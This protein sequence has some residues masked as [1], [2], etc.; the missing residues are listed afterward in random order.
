MKRYNGLYEKII[1]MDNLILADKMARK[2]KLHSYGVMLFDKNRE[3]NLK[4]LHEVL[5]NGEYHTSKYSTFTIF[6]PKERIIYR[7]PYFPDRIMHHAIMNIMCDIWVNT[8]TNDTYACIKGRGIH[9]CAN[10]IKHDLYENKDKK[11]YCLKLDIR[12]FYPSIDHEELKKVIRIK[13]KDNRLL[14]LL[15]EIIDSTDGVPIGNYLSQFFAN[16]FLSDIDHKIKEILHVRYYYRYADD[17]VI[18][19]EKKKELHK[20]K[21]FIDMQLQIRKLKMKDNW[22]IFPVGNYKYD[23][24]GRGIDFLGYV[25]YMQ[26]TYLRKGIKKNFMHTAIKLDGKHLTDR[27]LLKH[28]A[29]WYGWCKHANAKHLY[30]KLI[31]ESY[32]SK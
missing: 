27:K 24:S 25:F 15:D 28:E 6:E 1:S 2:R 13:I 10:K 8:M 26:C 22:Q 32:E 23:K 4:K 19:S 21:D 30:N 3:E 5:L 20:I 16:I 17:M 31:Q 29:A 7:L 18:L 9:K 14:A 12:K 11:M